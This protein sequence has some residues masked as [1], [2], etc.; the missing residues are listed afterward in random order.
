M[1]V[2]SSFI[3]LSVNGCDPRFCGGRRGVSQSLD[4]Y[5]LY[6]RVILRV[7]GGVWYVGLARRGSAVRK[8][9][10][11]PWNHIYL[12]GASR[13]PNRSEHLEPGGDYLFVQK[14]MSCR[15]Y[16]FLSL[17]S[18]PRHSHWLPPW[19]RVHSDTRRDVPSLAVL[20][21]DS[22]VE[23]SY[24]TPTTSSVSHHSFG[25]NRRLSKI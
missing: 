12:F 8:F 21:T 15:C 9:F 24:R 19:T 23:T 1:S 25:G 22:W 11:G 5:Y 4:S 6:V 3:G 10:L 13:R 14:R 7:P 16:G 18:I 20:F 17:W 2:F